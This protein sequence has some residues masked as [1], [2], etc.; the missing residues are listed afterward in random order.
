VSGCLGHARSNTVPHCSCGAM[1][2]RAGRFHVAGL[3][4][5]RPALLMASRRAVSRIG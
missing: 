1:R 3:G 5:R 2:H 4:A